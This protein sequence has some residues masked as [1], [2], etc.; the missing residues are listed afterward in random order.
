MGPQTGTIWEA[1]DEEGTVVRKRHV[2]H[3]SFGVAV[4]F[5][6]HRCLGTIVENVELQ[7]YP[8]LNKRILKRRHAYIRLCGAIVPHDNPRR[9]GWKKIRIEKFVF[10]IRKYE[11]KFK[12]FTSCGEGRLP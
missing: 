9:R 7:D 5:K 12:K 1:R 3:E 8:I 11:L 4:V 10:S 2:V 6:L